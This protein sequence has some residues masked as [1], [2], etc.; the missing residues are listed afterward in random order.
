MTE[1]LVKE[2]IQKLITNKKEDL[3]SVRMDLD[4]HLGQK[5]A[6][7]NENKLRNQLK[8]EKDK[9]GAKR[10]VEAIDTLETKVNELNIINKKINELNSIEPQIVE[11]IQYMEKNKN[12]IIKQGLDL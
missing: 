1:E 10:N 7:G 3:L 2:F 9:I 4:F 8:K 5:K 12:K 6:L 11:Y